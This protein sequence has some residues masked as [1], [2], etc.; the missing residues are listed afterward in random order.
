[1][2]SPSTIDSVEQILLPGDGSVAQ[3]VVVEVPPGCR[4]L[5]RRPSTRSPRR[6][7]GSGARRSRSLGFGGREIR[8]CARWAGCLDVAFGAAQAQE[9]ITA[10]ASPLRPAS[11]SGVWGEVDFTGTDGGSSQR[12]GV[13]EDP[14]HQVT[15]CGLQPSVEGGVLGPR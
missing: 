5:G 11:F 9:A 10:Q 4:G 14:G 7:P 15:G 2:I 13:A 6:R 3:V 8:I 12:A 1:V